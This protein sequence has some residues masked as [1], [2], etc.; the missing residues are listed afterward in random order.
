MNAVQSTFYAMYISFCV[1]F[2][3]SLNNPPPP[4]SPEKLYWSLIYWHDFFFLLL[5]VR[6]RFYSKSHAINLRWQENFISLLVSMPWNIDQNCIVFY[7]IELHKTSSTLTTIKAAAEA[8]GKKEKFFDFIV[9]WK[10]FRKFTVLK[11][12]AAWKNV[13]KMKSML[14]V[15]VQ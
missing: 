11:R 14:C 15:C 6:T 8:S 9:I 7:C 1:S 4:P 12:W 10:K 3:L 2:S 5:L 13:H